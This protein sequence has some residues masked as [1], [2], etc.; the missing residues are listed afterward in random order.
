ML[1]LSMVV[2]FSIVYVLDEILNNYVLKIDE[3][4]ISI[5]QFNMYLKFVKSEIEDN[6]ANEY[7]ENYRKDVWSTIMDNVSATQYAKDL[8]Y[9]R[10]IKDIICAEKAK[11]LGIEL[12]PEDIE[13]IEKDLTNDSLKKELARKSITDDEYRKIRSNEILIEYLKE[14]FSKGI[15]VSKEEIDEYIEEHN[16]NSETIILRRIIFRTT[17]SDLTAADKKTIYDKAQAIYER[18]KLGEDFKML[19]EE[20]SDYESIYKPG[21]LFE[22]VVGNNSFPKLEEAALA[23]E[24]GEISSVFESSYGYEIVKVENIIDTKSKEF[25]ATIEKEILEKKKKEAFNK[26]YEM[27]EK[28]TDIKRNNSV[29][30]SIVVVDIK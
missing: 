10:L 29:Y 16:E 12:L 4:K 3:Q 26:E 9:K 21:E 11:E 13:E 20:N 8:T 25:R 30:N 15:S 27:W 17:H 6:Y 28:L 18:A 23:L 22:L 7:G 5:E 1:V 14:R 2:M 24:E 19:S